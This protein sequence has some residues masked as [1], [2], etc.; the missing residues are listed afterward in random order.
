MEMSR[1][2]GNARIHRGA[3]TRQSL[4]VLPNY[5]QRAMYILVIPTVRGLLYALMSDFESWLRTAWMDLVS[6]GVLLL[7]AL[8]RWWFSRYSL[9]NGAL[10]FR[11]GF[12]LQNDTVILRDHVTSVEEERSWWMRLC[13]ATRLTVRSRGAS[14]TL[15]VHIRRAATLRELL[16]CGRQQNARLYRPGIAHL[17]LYALLNSDSLGG[18]IF[19]GVL[20]SRFGSI[21]GRE[22]REEFV[23][24]LTRLLHLVAYGVPG[25]M[26]TA[27]LLLLAVWAF[28]FAR[29]VVENAATELRYTPDRI[30][31]TSGSV[32]RRRRT[33]VTES[34]S[35]VEVR[36]TLPGL[37]FG[38]GTAYMDAPGLRSERERVLM[39]SARSKSL[40]L[41]LFRLLPDL[42]PARLAVRPF[43]SGWFPYVWMYG[44]ALL[45]L[46]PLPFVLGPLFPFWSP[47]IR[48][49][50]WMGCI[51]ALWLLA[52][53]F[54]G[55]RRSGV[56]LEDGRLTIVHPFLGSV[57]RVTVP[58]RDVRMVE[59]RRFCDIGR[60]CGLVFWIGQ[61]KLRRI[62]LGA[63]PHKESLRFV[64]ELERQG[65][66]VVKR[67]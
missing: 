14:V 44:A 67:G 58:L 3:W 53:S 34:I 55:F 24:A 45:V 18:V 65:A 38:I 7:V 60:G 47:M 17:G 11:Q 10:C 59:V 39:L 29:T 43:R 37:L 56:G 16:G 49:V 51:P 20:I 23:G 32:V 52:L 6:L 40:D 27:A 48:L 66:N 41:A 26:F 15:Y 46:I 62:A 22:V 30:T 21:L 61:E 28:S 33:V 4:S 63:M 35:A 13:R 54:L 50:S 12:L 31:L 36:R 25:A 64:E 19:A 9:V 2:G 42:R 1:S 8:F 57:R 5:L